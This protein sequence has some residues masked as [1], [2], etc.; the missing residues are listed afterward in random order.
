MFP[1]ITHLFVKNYMENCLK[2]LLEMQ[3]LTDIISCVI[4]M[5]M[6]N[7]TLE[8]DDGSSG[9]GYT[10]P[11]NSTTSASISLSITIDFIGCWLQA[12]EHNF[13]ERCNMSF[14]LRRNYFRKF[15]L[16]FLNHL[17]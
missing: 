14:F 1:D 4:L 6:K 3:E 2:N 11:L 7:N 12:L 16:N 13:L 8:H 10:M 9:G 17:V 15:Q 5:H